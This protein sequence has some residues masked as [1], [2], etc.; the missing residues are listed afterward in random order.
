MQDTGGTANGGVNLDASPNTITFNVTAVNDAPVATG[1]GNSGAEDALSI[2]VV[3][4]ASDVDG[5]V[6]S[7]RLTS[8]PTNG[9][10][11]LDA[12]MTLLV[13]TNTDIAP[14]SAG[15]LQVYFRPQGEWSGSTSFNFTAT[16]NPGS[17]SAAVTES[18]TVTPVNDGPPVAAADTFYT[19]AGTPITIS[20]AT[21]LGNDV[22]V[23]NA[24]ITN[25][26]ALT[27]TGSPV[28]NGNGTLTYTPAGLGASTFTY[29]LTDADGGR[30]PPPSR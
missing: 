17:T 7:F 9:A 11:Y 29:T 4:T 26:S 8:L 22:L 2:P 18:I 27:G 23:D 21:L 6:A 19:A 24:A 12:G 15:T 28:N 14:T 3:L 16:D 20:T 13:T 10:L 30:A 5:T 25:I 1:N